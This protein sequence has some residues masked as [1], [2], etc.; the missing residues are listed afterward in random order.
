MQKSSSVFLG[1]SLRRRMF[2]DWIKYVVEKKLVRKT[3]KR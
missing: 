3:E 2:D 1:G